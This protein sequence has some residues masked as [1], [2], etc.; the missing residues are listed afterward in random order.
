MASKVDLTTWDS[1]G[2]QRQVAHQGSREAVSSTLPKTGSV[3][4]H[5]PT[6]VLESSQGGEEGVG[7]EGPSAPLEKDLPVETT[8]VEHKCSY[9]VLVTL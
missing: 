1:R 4:P 8:R 6:R 3:S 7:Q 5:P 2:T 9:L